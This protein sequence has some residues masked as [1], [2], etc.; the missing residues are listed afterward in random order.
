MDEA[1]PLVQALLL[2]DGRIIAIG[3]KAVLASQSRNPDEVDLLGRTLLPGFID[4]HVHVRELGM[5]WRVSTR[6]QKWLS[7]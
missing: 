3:D 1:N 6:Q 2:R 7:A 5:I 4:S